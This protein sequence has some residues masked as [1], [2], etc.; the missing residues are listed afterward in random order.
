MNAALTLSKAS[1]RSSN[2]ANAVAVCLSC[3]TPSNVTA[4]ASGTGFATRPASTLVAKPAAL[5]QHHSVGCYCGTCCRGLHSPA[6]ASHS[7]TCACGS[8]QPKM[9]AHHSAC[10]C[11]ACSAPH[12]SSCACST[13]NVAAAG[14]APGCS[15]LGCRM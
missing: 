10:G 9:A 12:G 11:S 1:I 14:H 3:Y 4:F 8:C 15:C 7:A 13:C 6:I 2:A 5:Q